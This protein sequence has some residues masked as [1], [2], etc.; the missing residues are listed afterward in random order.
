ME[1]GDET[2]KGKKETVVRS[3]MG[4]SPIHLMKKSIHNVKD[5]EN[6]KV[7]DIK[8]RVVLF[9]LVFMYVF[10]LELTLPVL[11][12]SL[13]NTHTDFITGYV[14]LNILSAIIILVI[15]TIGILRY[16]HKKKIG[17]KFRY[18]K[19]SY[20]KGEDV[21]PQ[22]NMM[23]P[24]IVLYNMFIFYM[25]TRISLEFNIGYFEMFK[26]SSEGETAIYLGLLGLVLLIVWVIRLTW[27][28]IYL[29]ILNKYIYTT[30]D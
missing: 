2:T 15:S 24:Y 28:F 4:F 21:D 16:K 3:N 22:Y 5:K 23:L 29:K 14:V 9:L 13:R 6:S 19:D 30:K 8:R 12:F 7:D 26:V 10:S 25:F 27:N 17:W 20:Y 18:N 1:T 11:L